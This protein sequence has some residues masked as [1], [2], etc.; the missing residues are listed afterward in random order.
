M[1]GRLLV[2][3]GCGGGCVRVRHGVVKTRAGSGQCLTPRYD[4]IVASVAQ[5]VEQLTLNQRVK[6][7]SPFGGI[8]AE[9][10]RGRACELVLTA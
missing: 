1:W 10:S 5:L 7:S 9:W 8:L 4:G 3:R 2:M 6:G